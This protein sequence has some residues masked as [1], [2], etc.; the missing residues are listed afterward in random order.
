MG[1]FF[2]GVLWL[3]ATTLLRSL[4]A[5]FSWLL[6]FLWP[7]WLVFCVL[8]CMAVLPQP[9]HAGWGSWLWGSN[10]NPKQLERSAELAQQAARAAS[11]AAQAQ[12]R[13]AAAQSGQNAR[14]AET[15]TQ[16]SK[17]RQNLADHLRALSETSMQD[18]RVAAVLHASGP[19]SVCVAVLLL[20]GLA[21]WMVTRAGRIPENELVDA[22]DL[23]VLEMA[24]QHPEGGYFAGPK[25]SGPGNRPNARLTS[26]PNVAGQ[27][28]VAGGPENPDGPR[29]GGQP[30]GQLGQLTGQQQTQG[31]SKAHATGEDPGPMP[32]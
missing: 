31:R 32:F 22:V 16:L 4:A 13:Q 9:V 8:V 15:L 2:M 20:A 24:A 3:L 10:N 5:I 21:V 1:S 26:L 29:D 28:R 19:V 23:L 25:L 14:V 17:E 7:H 30:G 18:S 12:A 6:W 27:G 11:E